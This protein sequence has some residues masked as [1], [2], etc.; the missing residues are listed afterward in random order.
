MQCESYIKF[1]YMFCSRLLKYN[2]RLYSDNFT[3]NLFALHV[4]VRSNYI[5]LVN[6]SHILNR[7]YATRENI[8]SGV[9]SV[10][11]ISIVHWNRYHLYIMQYLFLDWLWLR[12]FHMYFTF[13]YL[14]SPSKGILYIEGILLYTVQNM[15]IQY[16][17]VQTRKT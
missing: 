3:D 17:I 8:A 4:H 11:Y 10:K 5:S 7:G 9:H 1:Y 13:P 2:S 14:F 15:C 16:W 12:V 6:N